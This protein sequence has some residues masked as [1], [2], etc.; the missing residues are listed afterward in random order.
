MLR[1]ISIENQSDLIQYEDHII[2]AEEIETDDMA[3][4]SEMIE[5]SESERITV[6]QV[7]AENKAKE[8]AEKQG[9]DQ[10]T[11]K[12][13]L[14]DAQNGLIKDLLKYREA[15]GKDC[16]D[17]MIKRIGQDKIIEQFNESEIRQAMSE[18]IKMI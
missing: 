17:A 1:Q 6:Q 12:D 7:E 5:Q 4:N 14:I 8:T 3:D 11:G 15:I 10:P 9:Q 16:F 13:K 2:G 18:C